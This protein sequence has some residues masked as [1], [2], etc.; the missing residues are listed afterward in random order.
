MMVA[1]NIEAAAGV[2]QQLKADAKHLPGLRSLDGRFMVINEAM[3]IPKGRPMGASYL[4]EFV[5]EMK[6]GG[7]S[8]MP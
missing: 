5:E 2:K 3:A 6:S 4:A 7:L 1:E 8:R